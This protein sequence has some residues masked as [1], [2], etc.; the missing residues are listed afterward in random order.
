MENFMSIKHIDPLNWATIQPV[1]DALLASSLTR[2]NLADWLGQWSDLEAQL[3]EFSFRAYR[4]M[5]EDTT[6]AE[7][8]KRFLY[9]VEELDPKSRVASQSLKEKLLAADTSQLPPATNEMVRRFR[10]EADLFR[11]VNIPL[12]TELDRL[13]NEFNK[14]M[15]AMNIEFDGQTQTMQQIQKLWSSP[16]RELRSRAWH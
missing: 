2:E 8:E 15:G 4:A 5:T 3:N 10:A 14:I 9:V 6:D 12:F 7:A 1:V 16:D 11:E 13:G